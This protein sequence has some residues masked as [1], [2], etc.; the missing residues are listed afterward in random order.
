MQQFTVRR[1]SVGFGPAARPAL[2]RDLDGLAAAVDLTSDEGRRDA[3]HRVAARLREAAGSATHALVVDAVKSLADAPPFFDAMAEELRERYPQ[4]T[5]RNET[6][7]PATIAG[8][9]TIP[10]QLVVT[11]VLGAVGS[12][13]PCRVDDRAGLLAALA[14][15]QANDALIVALEVI[16]SPSVESDR[17]SA[18]AMMSRYPELSALD[19]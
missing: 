2:Q 18:D 15:L 14:A 6:R 1:L 9:P 4:E 16:W 10:G 11:L 7:H 17:M 13:A 19:A 3:L 12:L 5:L 8:D